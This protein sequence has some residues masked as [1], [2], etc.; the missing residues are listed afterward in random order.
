MT[1]IY[2]DE[3]GDLGFDLTKSA[4]SRYFVV[5]VLVV[6]QTR[7]LARIV[8]KVFRKIKSIKKKRHQKRSGVLHCHKESPTT[9]KHL[10]DLLSKEDVQIVTL[11]LD[12]QKVRVKPQGKR[13]NLYNYVTNYLLDRIITE[14]IVSDTDEITLIASRRETSKYLNKNFQ[15][16][17]CDQTKQNHGLEVSI[18]IIPHHKDPGLQVVDFVSWSVF[19]KHQYQETD[20]IDIIQE[21]ITDAHELLI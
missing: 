19:R 16:Y 6:Q 5:T 10:L 15:E 3:S 11:L 8:K 1:T 18:E 21:C 2:L 13:Q 9:R 17:L 7:P 4:T 12:K 14:K 20:Y